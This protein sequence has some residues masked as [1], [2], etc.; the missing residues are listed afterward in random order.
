[1][2]N[3]KGELWPE[4]H[5]GFGDLEPAFAEPEVRGGVVVVGQK[6]GE[7][8]AA[9]DQRLAVLQSQHPRDTL[10]FCLVREWEEP[11]LQVP[12]SR[13]SSPENP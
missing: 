7:T 8:R 2:A 13:A 12:D 9:F 1:M 11:P 5:S 10:F 4:E 3:V 6:P